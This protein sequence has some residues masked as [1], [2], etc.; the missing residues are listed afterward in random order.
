[1]YVYIPIPIVRCALSHYLS[2][3]IS[4]SPIQFQLYSTVYIQ[5]LGLFSSHPGCVLAKYV[6]TIDFMR[7]LDAIAIPLSLGCSPVSIPIT[8]SHCY[9]RSYCRLQSQLYWIRVVNASLMQ[10]WSCR[11]SLTPVSRAPYLI[12]YHSLPLH[13]PIPTSVLMQ[14]YPFGRFILYPLPC[15]RYMYITISC[16]NPCTSPFRVII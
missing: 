13:I 1:M 8:H 5:F 11:W 12:L 7:S 10:W 9:N 15:K 2:Y 14:S 6:K 4:R 16:Q 3:S